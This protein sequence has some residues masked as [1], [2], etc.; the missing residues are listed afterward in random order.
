MPN[1]RRWQSGGGA[2]AYADAGADLGDTGW[3]DKA[4]PLSMPAART[5]QEEAM[6]AGDAE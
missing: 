2:P 3:H 6:P 1:V 4:P 5:A